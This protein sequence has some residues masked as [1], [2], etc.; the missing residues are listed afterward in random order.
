MADLLDRGRVGEFGRSKW[1][2]EGVIY[3]LYLPLL[4]GFLN[5]ASAADFH[6]AIEAWVNAA[7]AFSSTVSKDLAS[8]SIQVLSPSSSLCTITS[9]PSSVMLTFCCL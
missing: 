6:Q 1:D 3:F 7:Q 9:P 8:F 2:V 4:L 5:T